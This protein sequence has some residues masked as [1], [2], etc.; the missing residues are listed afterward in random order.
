M[1]L[2]ETWYVYR[3]QKDMLLL[4]L[5]LI[6]PNDYQSFIHSIKFDQHMFDGSLDMHLWYVFINV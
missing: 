4:L 3:L 1:D 5:L 2:D 6:L